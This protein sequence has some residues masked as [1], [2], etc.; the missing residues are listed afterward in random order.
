MM[1]KYSKKV[2]KNTVSNAIDNCI[3]REKRL[4]YEYSKLNPADS[5]RRQRDAELV[6]F[7]MMEMKAEIERELERM[8][9]I[10]ATV[11][12]Q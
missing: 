9:E 7:G 10:L 5:E 8:S 12:A 3:A 1:T 11:N 6:I 2:I 4:A